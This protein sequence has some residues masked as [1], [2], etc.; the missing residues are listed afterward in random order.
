MLYNC[1]RNEREKSAGLFGGSVLKHSFEGTQGRANIIDYRFGHSLQYIQQVCLTFT[2]PCDL[3]FNR[4]PSEACWPFSLIL[5]FPTELNAATNLFLRGWHLAACSQTIHYLLGV[6]NA[7]VNIIIVQ[8]WMHF[9]KAFDD[10][11]GFCTFHRNRGTR[12]VNRTWNQNRKRLLANINLI[13]MRRIAMYLSLW[14]QSL[15]SSSS[16]DF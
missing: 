9:A 2:H 12:K 15:T 7:L 5:L 13:F 11:F 6:S 10:S 16:S 8:H 14:H 4:T 3:T 1:S